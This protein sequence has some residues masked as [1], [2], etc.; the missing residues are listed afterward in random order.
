MEGPETER[1]LETSADTENL[2]SLILEMER[3]A[4]EESEGIISEAKKEAD[5]RLQYA[6]SQAQS[7][8]QDAED[9]AKMQSETKK[10]RLLSGISIEAKRRSIQIRESIFN[11]V[12]EKARAVLHTMVNK[13][14]YRTVVLN[15]ITEAAIG[16]GEEKAM[17]NASQPERKIIDEGLL[18]E[19]ERNVHTILGNRVKLTLS[20]ESALLGQGVV[21]TSADDRTAFNNQIETRFRRKTTEIRKLIYEKLFGD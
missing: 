12:W 18:R 1:R 14:G 5:R 6:E 17:V 20:K 10:A 3:D 16:L 15:L 13:K 9:K 8:I 7:I 2:N 21:L 19:A 4:N 11:E